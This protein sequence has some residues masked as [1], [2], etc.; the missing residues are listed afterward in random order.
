MEPLKLLKISA[1][2]KAK[3]VYKKTWIY[4]FVTAAGR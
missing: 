3:N 4:N 2:S 1:I